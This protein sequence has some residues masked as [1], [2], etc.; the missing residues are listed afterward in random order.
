MADVQ[1]SDLT[2]IDIK[3]GS[4]PFQLFQSWLEEAK[5]YGRLN[6]GF[7][8]L[9]TSNEVGDVTNRTVVLRDFKDNY[10]VFLSNDGSRKNQQIAK[11]PKVAACFLWTY[12]KDEKFVI[13]QVRV[14]GTAEPMSKEHSEKYYEREPLHA[15]IR[16]HICKQGQ[17][18]DWNEL[19]TEHD[20]MLKQV[21]ENGLELSMP[22]HVSAFKIT[23]TYFDFYFAWDNAI[24]DRLIFEK[25]TND[26]TFNRVGT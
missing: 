11:N 10:L 19:K 24:A 18:T 16:A 1:E 3:P 2:Y 6:N 5:N 12:E 22:E 17:K 8:N 21:R 23:P 4:S 26:W 13:R 14:E 15:K 7:F 25:T 9:A 20:E